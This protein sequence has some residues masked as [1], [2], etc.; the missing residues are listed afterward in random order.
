MTRIRVLCALAALT[1][2]LLAPMAGALAADIVYPPGSRTGLAPAADLKPSSRFSGFEDADRKVAVAIVELPGAAY[3]QMTP[4][5]LKEPAVKDAGREDFAFA[6]GKGVLISGTL[7]DKGVATRRW[8]LVAP[9]APGEANS[10]TTLVR[11]DV[12]EAARDAYGDA[13]VRAMLKTVTFRTVPQ[14]EL[15]GLLPFNLNDMAGFRIVKIL[16]GSVV[17]TDGPS[18][19]IATQPFAIVSVGRGAP[20]DEERGRFAR[21][22]LT[23]APVRGLRVT[24]ADAMRISGAPGYELRATG[25]DAKG[26]EMKVVQW[27]RFG[28]SGFLAV[29]GVASGEKWDS[30]FNRFRAVR[31]GVDAK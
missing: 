10:P 28:G 31:D 26:K 25:E 17:V 14:E 11:V 29:L 7:D 2:A 22:L 3:E 18:D 15:L 23:G 5:L 1:A 20:S 9:P 4:A 12:P 6:G 16:P 21:D 24:S 27:V 30:M 19:D 8:F 13:T